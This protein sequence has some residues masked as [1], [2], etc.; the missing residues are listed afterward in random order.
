MECF[1]DEFIISGE[2]SELLMLTDEGGFQF[3]Y[4]CRW[5]ISWTE[6][7]SIS[8][9]LMFVFDLKF[10]RILQL[11]WPNLYFASNSFNRSIFVSTE[12]SSEKKN[13]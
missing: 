13:D 5:Q 10:P 4:R 1:S 11:F 8:C 3:D 6:F 7:T 12:T 9:Q 2:I